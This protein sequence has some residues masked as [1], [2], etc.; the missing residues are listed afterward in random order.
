MRD[1]TVV[2]SGFKR[3][4]LLQQQYDAVM[5][6][7]IKPAKV[8]VWHN[9]SGQAPHLIDGPVHIVNNE[10]TG[11]WSRFFYCLNNTTEFTCVLDDDCVPAPGW[12]ENCLDTYDKHHC[13]VGGAGF[14]FHQPNVIYTDVHTR[15][16]YG[17][18]KPFRQSVAKRAD[19]SGHAW[20]FRT[21]W[22]KYF[23]QDM[24]NLRVY[25]TCGE[26]MHFNF[27]LQRAGIH[28]YIAPQNDGNTCCIFED[29]GGSHEATF[30]LPGQLTKMNECFDAQRA[31]AWKL[32]CEE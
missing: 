17:H 22:L 6:Q 32:I 23:V 24:P 28:T 19:V 8:V 4:H 29:A 30:R 18:D 12:L 5:S 1:I 10:N 2:L 31:R 7:S 25:N 27:V 16:N 11:V 9:A 14:Y 13:M 3:Y 26:D 15:S 20:F 21:E